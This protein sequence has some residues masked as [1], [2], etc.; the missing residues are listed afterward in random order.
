MSSPRSQDKPSSAPG[1][2]PFDRFATAVAGMV[3][4]AWFFAS[5]LLTIV[6]WAPTILWFKLDTWQLLINTWTTLITY[7]LVALLQN[8]QKRDMQALHKK[9][10]AI[11]DALANFME[12]RQK[13]DPGLTCDVQ[14]L[15]EAVGLE[16]RE[17][18]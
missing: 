9:V 16:H 7:L 15:R 10:N 18:S 12:S 3:S 6:V 11:A 13:D 1:P 14:E 5:C 17:R 4:K 8:T 2:T